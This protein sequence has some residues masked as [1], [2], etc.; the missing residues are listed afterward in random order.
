MALIKL[1]VEELLRCEIFT[2]T[3]VPK[4]IANNKA[5]TKSDIVNYKIPYV[6]HYS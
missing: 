2:Y 3:Q 6:L 1:G 5:T 4:P